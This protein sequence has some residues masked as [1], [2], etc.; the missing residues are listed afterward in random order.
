[1]KN[2]FDRRTKPDD[3]QQGDLVLKWDARYEDKGKHGKFDHLQK[4]PSQVAYD[5]GN[6]TYV[7]QEANGDLLV[8]EPVNDHFL[9][10]YLTQ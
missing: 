8:G 10:H 9:R 6:N 4:G 2:I 1:M 7:V 3:F 5:Q